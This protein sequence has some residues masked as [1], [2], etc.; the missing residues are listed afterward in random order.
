MGCISCAGAVLGESVLTL[1]RKESGT[2]PVVA[3][4]ICPDRFAG[5]SQAA[6][7]ALPAR[8][9]D[10]DVT[11]G[12]LFEID[13]ANPFSVNVT[14]DLRMVERIGWGM[15]M[16]QVVAAGDVGAH[17]G[18]RLSG[19]ELVVLGDAGEWAGAG[20]AGGRLIVEGRAGDGVGA[21]GPAQQERMSGGTIVV[22]GDAGRG[23]GTGMDDGMIVVLGGTGEETGAG[24]RGG[25]IFV[26]GRLGRGPG[27][28]MEGGSI[29]ALDGADGLP[30]TFRP[31]STY[32]PVFPEHFL[33]ELRRWG[34]AGEKESVIGVFRRYLGDLDDVGKGE[35]L[36]RDQSQ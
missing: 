9:G 32:S 1:R 24:M 4:T 6:I 34:L 3:E 2:A 11:L 15:S 17:V 21:A 13:G 36:L 28:G 29:V 27:I 10:E 23:V 16:G 26:A 35:I 19:G 14:G 12:D 5:L 33:R 20:L 22:R 31:A 30:D 25:A 18:A 8:H 7:A